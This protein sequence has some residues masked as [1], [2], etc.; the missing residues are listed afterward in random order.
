M[1]LEDELKQKEFKSPYQKGYL[2]ILFTANW[3]ENQSKDFFQ[4]YDLTNQQYNVLR[5]LRGHSPEPATV[6]YLKER[7]IDKMCD[8]SRIVERLR[9]K[10]L[11]ERKTCKEDRRSV[12]IVIT[13]KGQDLLKKIDTQIDTMNAALHNLTDSELEQ[14]NTLL[15]KIRG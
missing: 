6:G 9:I 7:I 5:I 10:E 11:I 12:D 3:L 4:Q 1:R 13:P 2:N 8:V 14:L 15:D